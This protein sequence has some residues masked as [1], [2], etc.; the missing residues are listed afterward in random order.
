MQDTNGQ[1][2]NEV[3]GAL[4]SLFQTKVLRALMSLDVIDWVISTSC[5]LSK[6]LT[7]RTV[8]SVARKDQA[9]M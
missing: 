8:R 3:P 7:D 6:S 5:K 9:N 2:N 1:K 4:F